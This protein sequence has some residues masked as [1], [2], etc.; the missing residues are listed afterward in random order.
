MKKRLLIFDFD[1]TIADTLVVALQIINE[2]GGEFNLPNVSRTQFMELKHKSVPELMKM[3]GL[4]WF[5]LPLFV[6]RARLKFKQHLKQVHPIHGMP[7]IL[8][9]LQERGYR[10]GILTSNTSEGVNSFL[11]DHEIPGFEFIH[12]PDHIFGKSRVIRQIL[13]HHELKEEEV[14]MIG[15]EIR[16]VDAARKVGIESIAVTW[17]F[18]SE[19]LLRTGNPSHLIQTPAELLELLA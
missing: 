9:A 16:D 17:G 5:Q 6:H 1:G 3:S 19:E 11:Q 2:I 10:M 4:S 14:V 15:D 8:A 13:R 7:E 12:A 18:N